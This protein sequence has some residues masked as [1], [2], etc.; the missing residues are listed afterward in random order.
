MLTGPANYTFVVRGQNLAIPAGELMDP[1]PPDTLTIGGRK[2]TRI[3]VVNASELICHDVPAG[4]WSLPEVV[5][6][7]GGQNTAAPTLLSV[8]GSPLI[9]GVE[10]PSV[11]SAGGVNITLFG[12][13]FGSRIGDVARVDVNGRPCAP[14]WHLSSSK[15][16]CT[17]PAGHGQGLNVQVTNALGL[18][19]LE[20]PL[21][22]YDGP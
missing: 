10:P 21:L 9:S 3:T 2:C 1:T 18:S 8:V 20:A 14:L 5:L 6:R 4:D 7:L 13:A 15:I 19:S 16:K 12:S 22:S 17:S 11:S